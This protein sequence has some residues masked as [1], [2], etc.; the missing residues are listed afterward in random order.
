MQDQRSRDGVGI[1]AAFAR[2]RADM[3]WGSR[4]RRFDSSCLNQKASGASEARQDRRMHEHGL[5]LH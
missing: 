1:F 4:G 3:A 5:L 2:L